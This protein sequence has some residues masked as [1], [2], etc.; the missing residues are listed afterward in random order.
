[1]APEHAK[2]ANELLDAVG[3]T[4]LAVQCER[5]GLTDGINDLHLPSRAETLARLI[6]PLIDAMSLA[7]ALPEP[8]PLETWPARWR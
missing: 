3:E 2:D 4:F 5:T 7:R 1:M 8:D 6:S